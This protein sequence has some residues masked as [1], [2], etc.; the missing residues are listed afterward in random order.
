MTRC[1]EKG[2]RRSAL[3]ASEIVPDQAKQARSTDLVVLVKRREW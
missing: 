2:F 3:V 1:A